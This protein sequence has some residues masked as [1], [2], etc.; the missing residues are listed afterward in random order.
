M[1]SSAQSF[2]NMELVGANLQDKNL[3]EK[4]FD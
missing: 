1:L 3:V 4:F 2:S